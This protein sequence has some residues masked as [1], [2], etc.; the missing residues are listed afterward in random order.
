MSRCPVCGGP[1][2]CEYDADGFP[3]YYCVGACWRD[4]NKKLRKRAQEVLALLDRMR[5]RAGKDGVPADMLR[6]AGL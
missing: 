1:R 2:A 4:Q 3:L 6:K 5:R